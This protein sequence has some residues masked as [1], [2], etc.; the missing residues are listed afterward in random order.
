MFSV[1]SERSA[2]DCRSDG[3]ELQ[4][5]G[6]VGPLSTSFATSS[7]KGTPNIYFPASPIRF[8]NLEGDKNERLDESRYQIRFRFPLYRGGKPNS[9]S[10]LAQFGFRFRN[11]SKTA[12]PNQFNSAFRQYLHGFPF[13]PSPCRSHLSAPNPA[14]RAAP[15]FPSDGRLFFGRC[16]WTSSRVMPGGVPGR[17]S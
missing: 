12:K 5:G 6:T 15:T 1:V 13:T 11:P 10:S 4:L 16:I 9:E 8:F 14:W 2:G 7:R 17:T 3:C